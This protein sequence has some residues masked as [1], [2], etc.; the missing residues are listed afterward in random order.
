MGLLGN[1]IKGVVNIA[2]APIV[3][4]TDVVKGDF[5][6]TGDIFENVVNIIGDSVEDITNGD[7]I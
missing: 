6:N 1:L 3:I 2:V 5:E 7:I 4:V